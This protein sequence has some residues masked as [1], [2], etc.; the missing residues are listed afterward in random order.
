MKKTTIDLSAI[1]INSEFKQAF[2][3]IEQTR[4]HIF[5]TGKA[6][7]GKSTFLKF[8]RAQTGKKIVVLAPT[9][10]A[11]V[12]IQGQTVHSFFNFRPDITVDLIRSLYVN[13]AM[14]KLYRNL[15]TIIIDEISMVRADLMD[16]VDAFLRIYGPRAAEPFGGVQMIF[17]GDM[18]QLAPVVRYNE[19]EIFQ[20]VYRS[21]YFFDAKI[22]AQMQVHIIE[23][24]K[25][26]RQKDEVFVNL[27]NHVRAN[28]AGQ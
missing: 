26:Y 25:N 11:A 15:D 4:K 23:F 7:T 8:F 24:Q 22:F 16:C 10:V 28:T 1:D 13:P 18:Y 14:I 9:G 19:K 27:L 12:N 6:G 2:E 3:E 5:I 21:P 17:I 20:T